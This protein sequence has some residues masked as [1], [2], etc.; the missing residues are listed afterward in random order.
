M[1]LGNWDACKLHAGPQL[2]FL[3]HSSHGIAYTFLLQD[4]QTILALNPSYKLKS[5]CRKNL[6]LTSTNLLLFAL[7][8]SMKLNSRSVNLSSVM[9]TSCTPC[10]FLLVFLIVRHTTVVIQWTTVIPGDFYPATSHNDIEI[11]Y[12]ASEYMNRTETWWFTA[13]TD[14][15]LK[16]FKLNWTVP[17]NSPHITAIWHSCFPAPSYTGIC[18]QVYI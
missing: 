3:Q 2:K 14:A 1:K 12:R 18:M 4:S 16:Q 11:E 15:Q 9:S 7:L 17:S 5:Y 13:S 6:P 8:P 10:N